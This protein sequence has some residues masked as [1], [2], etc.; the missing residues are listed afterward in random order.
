MYMGIYESGWRPT[1]RVLAI[2]FKNKIPG[3]LSNIFKNNFHPKKNEI[4][5][6]NSIFFWNLKYFWQY[7]QKIPM[8]MKII[9]S[10]WVN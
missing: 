7:I 10:C 2:F 1:I 5:E 4:D 6:L 3:P 9:K 8:R